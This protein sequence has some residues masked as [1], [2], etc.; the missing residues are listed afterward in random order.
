MPSSKSLLSLWNSR[1]SEVV[2]EAAAM[3]VDVE[4]EEEAEV[5]IKEEEG[6]IRVVAVIM[7]GKETQCQH[8]YTPRLGPAPLYRN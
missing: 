7:D 8:T 3:E 2:E 5:A 4:A 6:V 1:A